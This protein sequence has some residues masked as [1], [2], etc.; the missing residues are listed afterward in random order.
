M[1][2][3]C[4]QCLRELW[5]EKRDESSIEEGMANVGAIED[6][7]TVVGGVAVCFAHA[8]DDKPDGRA[9]GWMTSL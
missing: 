5:A 7:V 3:K 2:L 6:A 1:T 9:G 4:G 8:V